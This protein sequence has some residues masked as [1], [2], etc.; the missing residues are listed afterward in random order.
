[1]SIDEL[2]EDLW[3]KIYCEGD[4]D[5]V[6]RILELDPRQAQCSSKAFTLLH[7]AA[8]EGDCELAQELLTLG[9]EVDSTDRRGRTPL[10]CAGE[11]SIPEMCQLLVEAG[12]NPT[13]Q[14]SR[15][16]SPLDRALSGDAWEEPEVRDQTVAILQAAQKKWLNS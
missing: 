10:H 4:V 14:D 8:T 6:R 11:A 13:M 9:A 3:E 1:M 12:A 7:I 16:R 5:D 15:G 2:I